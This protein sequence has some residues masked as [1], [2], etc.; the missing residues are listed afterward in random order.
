[1]TYMQLLSM[2]MTTKTKQKLNIEGK[3]LELQERELSLREAKLQENRDVRR[4]QIKENRDA[5]REQME[6][7]LSII[8]K[9]AK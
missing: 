4:A 9:L 6:M 8:N 5:R 2:V 7:M 3:N 1:M